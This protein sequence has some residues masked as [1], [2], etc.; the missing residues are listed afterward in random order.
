M[1]RPQR[2]RA[3]QDAL[4]GGGEQYGHSQRVSRWW[5]LGADGGGGESR[6]HLLVYGGG[7]WTRGAHCKMSVTKL[8]RTLVPRACCCSGKLGG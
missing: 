6:R 7:F 1:L 3:V 2:S 8:R 4:L 5:E